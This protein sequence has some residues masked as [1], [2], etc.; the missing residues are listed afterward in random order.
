MGNFPTP[1]YRHSQLGY[2][3][4]PSFHESAPLSS[5]STQ[6]SNYVGT[7][8]A[9][10]LH[11]HYVSNP[12]VLGPYVLGPYVLGPYVLGRVS[13]MFTSAPSAQPLIGEV[14][15]WASAGRVWAISGVKE[16]LLFF[17]RKFSINE[18]WAEACYYLKTM[19][20]NSHLLSILALGLET[21]RSQPLTRVSEHGRIKKKGRT[22][23]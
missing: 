6:T 2:K 8:A 13:G 18:C 5:I 9:Y 7:R 10:F 1:I 19:P 17:A 4:S 21:T 12:Y 14:D 20:M 11:S 23:D 22:H 3:L 15:S 16:R